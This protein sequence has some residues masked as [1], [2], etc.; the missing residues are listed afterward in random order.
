MRLGFIFYFEVRVGLS[1]RAVRVLRYSHYT[2]SDSCRFVLF[3]V[4][5]RGRWCEDG[6][7]T[8]P[9]LPKK[10]GGA[11]PMT[12]WLVSLLSK[13]LEWLVWNLELGP[14]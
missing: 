11:L 14:C 6:S 10:S 5:A 8:T 13:G 4:G 2:S 7:S 9:L 12:G 1:Y 3:C